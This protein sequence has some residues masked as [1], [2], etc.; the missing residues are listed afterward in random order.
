M[1]RQ[2]RHFG[3]LVRDDDAD[4][5]CAK[6]NPLR[7]R[8]HP[9]PWVPEEEGAEEVRGKRQKEKGNPPKTI[10]QS[11][12]SDRATVR[13]S[14]PPFSPEREERQKTTSL[15]VDQ[16]AIK[17]CLDL[18][19][20]TSPAPWTTDPRGGGPILKEDTTT[21]LQQWMICRPFMARPRRSTQANKNSM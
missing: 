9:S 14:L 8:E 12:F 10:Q 20:F 4:H 15:R 5:A 2:E 19:T 1:C 13:G 11:T 7:W 6:P 16:Q 3:V 17:S 21:N 18:T